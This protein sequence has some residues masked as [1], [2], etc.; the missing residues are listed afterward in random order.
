V[1]FKAKNLLDPDIE[2]SQGSEATRYTEGVGREY[3]ITV[4]YKF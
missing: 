2:L 1:K 3:S 4:E